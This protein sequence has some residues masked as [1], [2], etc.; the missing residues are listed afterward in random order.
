MIIGYLSAQKKLPELVSRIVEPAD[1]DIIIVVSDGVTGALNQQ[2]EK[3][4]AVQIE[5]QVQKYQHA[6]AEEI[7]HAIRQELFSYT[8]DAYIQTEF[9]IIVIKRCSGFSRAHN[10]SQQVL[11]E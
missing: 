4:G 11:E 10:G 6:S 9:S 3:F 7:L 5:T 2:R 8:R 1:G